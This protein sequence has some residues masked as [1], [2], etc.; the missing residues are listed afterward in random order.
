MKELVRAKLLAFLEEDLG[1]GDITS[2]TV[3]PVGTRASAQV[4]TRQSGVVAGIEEALIL[5]DIAGLV[6]EALERDGSEVDADR[7]VLW[8]DGAARDILG[9]E[10]T[11]LNLMGHMSGIATLT[12]Q[13]VDSVGDS[14]VRIA[15]TRKTLPGLRWFEKRAVRLG[16]ADSH[17]YELADAVLIKD[18]HL[19]IAGDVATAVERAREGASFTHKIEVEVESLEDALAATAAGADIL[20]IDN[21]PPEGVRGIVQALEEAGLRGALTLEASGGI[22]IEEIPQYAETG[23]DVLSLG[24]LTAAASSFD[25]SLEISTP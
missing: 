12:R 20:L 18:N 8:M 14:R 17:R 5:C 4:L 16:G 13:A 22:S 11:L 25:Y 3:I 23:V 2:Q 7:P 1:R 9:I 15:A 24:R 19:E 6:G 10:R 21:L